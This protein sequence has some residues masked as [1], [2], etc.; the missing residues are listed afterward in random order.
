[1]SCK[2]LVTGFGPFQNVKD[3]PSA[4]LAGAV[5]VPF[6][7]IEVSWDAVD[8]WIATREAD[9]YGVILH[10]GYADRASM[11]PE[12]I[13]HNFNGAMKD[14]RG[15]SRHGPINPSNRSILSSRLWTREM[16]EQIVDNRQV[17]VSG[18]AGSYLCNYIL[19]RTLESFPDP[20]VGFVHVPKFDVIPLE[21]QVEVVRQILDSF[22]VGPVRKRRDGS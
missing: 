21:R 3:N 2:A 11:T 20:G 22:S 12:L 14:M 15:A 1:M 13:A 5:G 8:E 6:R 9:Q 4:V 19:Y 7:I 17:R 18:D 10:L 16:L